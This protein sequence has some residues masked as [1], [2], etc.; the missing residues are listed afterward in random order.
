M[1]LHADHFAAEGIPLTEFSD[2]NLVKPEPYQLAV[3]TVKDLGGKVLATNQV[4]APVSTEMHCDTCHHNY[5]VEDI[6]T[7]RVE[8]NILT[9]HD[10]GHTVT[11]EKCT[12][13]HLTDPGG[14]IHP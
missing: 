4:V 10:L 11:L 13:C 12:V 9:L 3:I 8:T 1:D 7:G 5:G 2:S 6:A 14:E